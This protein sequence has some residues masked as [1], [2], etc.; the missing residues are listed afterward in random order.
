MNDANS[1]DVVNRIKAS[2]VAVNIY[3]RWVAQWFPA[4]VQVT[5]IRPTKD[6]ASENADVCDVITLENNVFVKNEVKGRSNRFT[7]KDDF[8]RDKAIVMSK[9]SYDNKVAK[10]G[11]PKRFIEL[12][13][14]R[15]YFAL[16]DVEETR[17]LWEVEPIFDPK[18]GYAT[19]C[20]VVS[21]DECVFGR[22]KKRSKHHE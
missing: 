19:E 10:Y 15:K 2:E 14:D 5:R 13:A 22:L 3:A 7:G 1:R 8:P 16:I 6:K 11:P 21:K 4:W 18:R 12:S 9:R 20:Y 17:D